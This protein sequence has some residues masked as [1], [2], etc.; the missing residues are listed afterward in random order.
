MNTRH[1]IGRR[2]VHITQ[3]RRK[4]SVTGSLV[5]DVQ[6][7][8]LDNGDIINTAVDVLD[9]DFAVHME[10]TRNGEPRR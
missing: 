7:I 10:V 6:Q 2:I 1:A 8:W 3:E 5:Y 4:N 9:G